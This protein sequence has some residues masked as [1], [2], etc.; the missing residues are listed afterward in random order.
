MPATD[1]EDFELSDDES[2]ISDDEGSAPAQAP[3]AES[4]GLFTG[5][6]RLTL[7]PSVR[8]LSR[9]RLR[10]DIL[11]IPTNLAFSCAESADTAAAWRDGRDADQRR[12]HSLDWRLVDRAGLVAGHQLSLD[13]PR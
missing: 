6:L 11:D 2:V 13:A 1:S 10:T 4:V 12:A 9:S 5:D 8:T 3:S 7:K